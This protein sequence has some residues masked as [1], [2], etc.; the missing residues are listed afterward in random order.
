L[1]VDLPSTSRLQ[2]FDSSLRCPKKLTQST[3]ERGRTTNQTPTRH[4][5]SY[6][7]DRCNS[8]G[9]R[10]SCVRPAKSATTIGRQGFLLATQGQ[11]ELDPDDIRPPQVIDW[12]CAETCMVARF[13]DDII[14]Q[15]SP[16]CLADADRS[17]RVLCARGEYSRSDT[18]GELRALIYSLRIDNCSRLRT[19]YRHTKLNPV[20][21]CVIYIDRYGLLFA[22]LAN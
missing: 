8:N 5:K 18:C 15:E 9:L 16:L 22:T 21:K 7:S 10:N 1:C 12:D 4:S 3:I 19:G 11:L 20:P 6:Q 2:L 14:N 17:P 13:I